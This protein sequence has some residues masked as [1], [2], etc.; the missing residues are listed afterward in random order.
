M[1]YERSW[2]H[3]QGNILTVTDPHQCLKQRLTPGLTL[4]LGS[5]LHKYAACRQGFGATVGY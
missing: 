5:I 4:M 3:K 2:E 1:L